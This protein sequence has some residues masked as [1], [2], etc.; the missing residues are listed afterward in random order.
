MRIL[1]E[2]YCHAHKPERTEM[3]TTRIFIAWTTAQWDFSYNRRYKQIHFSMCS[4]P[5]PRDLGFSTF[6]N[7]VSQIVKIGYPHILY[8]DKRPHGGHDCRKTRTTNN[9][10][11]PLVAFSE[12]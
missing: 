4:K 6:P 12:M 8:K 10:A 3:G 7:F 5:C 2:I 11:Q 9:D 1:G